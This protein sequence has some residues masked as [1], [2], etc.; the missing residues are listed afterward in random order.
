MGREK[1]VVHKARRGEGRVWGEK[2]GGMGRVGGGSGTETEGGKKCPPIFQTN[3]FTPMT[4]RP[5]QK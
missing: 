2:G 5:E 1:G 3:W 4:V